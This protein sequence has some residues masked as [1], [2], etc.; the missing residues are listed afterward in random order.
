MRF[1]DESKKGT[2]QIC[3]I[4]GKGAMETLAVIRQAFREESVSCTQ[5]FE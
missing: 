1:H 3:A 5:M 4:L 2:H